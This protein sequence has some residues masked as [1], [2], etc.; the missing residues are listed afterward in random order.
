MSNYPRVSIEN[1]PVFICRANGVI[2]KKGVEDLNSIP[3]SQA[4]ASKSNFDDKVQGRKNGGVKGGALYNQE[5]TDHWDK[6]R[7]R[8]KIKWHPSQL[9]GYVSNEFRNVKYTD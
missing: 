4:K 7:E 9:N 2:V 3:T 6:Y 8:C 1:G 5:N